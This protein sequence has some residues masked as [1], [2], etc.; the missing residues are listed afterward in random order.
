M[1]RRLTSLGL[2]IMDDRSRFSL[3]EREA[4]KVKGCLASARDLR[5]S[6]PSQIFGLFRCKMLPNGL[7]RVWCPTRTI[8]RHRP[9]RISCLTIG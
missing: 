7:V 1:E 4:A 9:L 5:E 3:R 6:A 8:G 2:D